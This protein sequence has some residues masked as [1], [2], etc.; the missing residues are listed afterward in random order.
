MLGNSSGLADIDPVTQINHNNSRKGKK[1]F[2][3]KDG[4]TP[5][6]LAFKSGL[7][8]ASVSSLVKALIEVKADVNAED[9]V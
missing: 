3:K 9:N 6:L 8:E 5:L 1:C 4:L 7:S 2:A